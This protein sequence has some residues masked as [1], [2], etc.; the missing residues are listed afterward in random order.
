MRSTLALPHVRATAVIAVGLFGIGALA[1]ENP[2]VVR[3]ATHFISNTCSTGATC[4]QWTNTS[5]GAAIRGASDGASGVVG[6]TSYNSTD[7]LHWKAGIYGADL[8]TSGI[9]DRGVYGQTA[10]GIGTYGAATGSG[11][12]VEGKTNGGTAVFGDSG[13]G[14]GVEGYSAGSDYGV[15]AESVGSAGLFASGGSD[16][17]DAIGG[18]GVG[19]SAQSNSANP[20]ISGLGHTGEAGSF[21]TTGADTIPAIYGYASAS[22]TRGADVTGQFAGITARSPSAEFPLILTDTAS[23]PNTVFFVD[24]IGNVFYLGTLNTFVRTASGQTALAY[25]SKTTSPTVEDNGTAR[26]VN[27]SAVVMLDL[28]FASMMDSRAAY[29]VMLT[30]DG[31]TRGLYVATKSAHYFVVREVQG[32]HGTLNFDYH[33][34]GASVGTAGVRAAFINEAAYGPHAPTPPRI[35]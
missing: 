27:G 23:T 4:Y 8:S 25:G 11:L 5:T 3:A 10:N 31:D 32:G 9:Y 35:K 33:I 12:G 21:T 15:E 22:G 19:V 6:A 7:F 1:A 13:S 14:I 24:G 34:Y 2:S 29:Q 30:P 18:T 16:G 20:A 28:T 17:I 26:L